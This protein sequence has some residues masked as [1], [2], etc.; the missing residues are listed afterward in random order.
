[1]AKNKSK[2]EGTN[3]GNGSSEQTKPTEF[4]A[5]L[6]VQE[7]ADKR[8]TE[9]ATALKTKP[10]TRERIMAIKVHACNVIDLLQAE[11]EVS[12]E[13]KKYWRKVKLNISVR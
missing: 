6:S 12:E 3:E 5:T 7:E 4:K 9:S 13:E 2:E 11:R 1:M 8:M 10:D